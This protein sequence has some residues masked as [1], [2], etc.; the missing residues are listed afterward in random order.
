MNCARL[1]QKYTFFFSN[2]FIMGPFKAKNDIQEDRHSF[3]SWGCN[4]RLSDT[5]CAPLGDIPLDAARLQRARLSRGWL[6]RCGTF[7]GIHHL[8]AAVVSVDAGHTTALC[9]VAAL[10]GALE[11][12]RGHMWGNT[13]SGWSSRF[14][15]FYCHSVFRQR[16]NT[17]K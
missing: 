14:K 12:R 5:Y 1:L 10:S 6:R 13:L 7:G 4:D 2:E 17:E 11:T 8:H 9:A 15:I 16:E 3:R